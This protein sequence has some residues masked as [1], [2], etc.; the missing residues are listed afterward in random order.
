MCTYVHTRWTSRFNLEAL[1]VMGNSKSLVPSECGF[2]RPCISLMLKHFLLPFLLSGDP[3]GPHGVRPGLV[4]PPEPAG[5]RWRAARWHRWGRGDVHTPHFVTCGARGE[6]GEYGGVCDGG[7][8]D[9]AD[10]GADDIHTPHFVTCGA[11]AEYEE[12]G[13]VWAA[14]QDAPRAGERHP[15]AESTAARGAPSPVWRAPWGGKGTSG[16]KGRGGKGTAC[17]G[18]GKSAVWVMG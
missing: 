5:D 15:K 10:G 17:S 16:R 18:G 1:G 14:N 11:R 13:G 3:I 8:P 2:A 4:L 6:Y 7:P 12:Y 9:D